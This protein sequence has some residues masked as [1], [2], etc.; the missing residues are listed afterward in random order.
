MSLS[1]K[2]VLISDGGHPSAEPL[3]E[4]FH[5]EGAA[6][7]VN[8]PAGGRFSFD[9]ASPDG[10]EGLVEAVVRA[11]GRLDVLLHN[12][13]L[14]E[15]KDFF[16][17]GEEDVL[18]SLRYNLKTAFLLTQAAGRRMKERGDGNLLYL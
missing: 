2:I 9:C 16:Q 17:C 1:G 13:N 3:A 8:D 14:V 6:V 7:A 10:A 4:R 5:S 15:A 18:R 12:H 11:F